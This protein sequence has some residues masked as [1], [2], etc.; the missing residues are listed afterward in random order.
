MNIDILKFKENIK[1]IYDYMVLN[2]KL[3]KCDLIIGCGC[4]DTNIPKKCASLLKEGYAKKILFT[5]GYGTKGEFASPEAL[6][7]KNIAIEEGIKEEDIIVEKEATNTGDN[8]RYSKKII[9]EKNIPSNKILIVHNALSTRR[10]YLTAQN[11]L[12]DKKLIITYPDLTFDEFYK[13]LEQKKMEE[14][15]YTISVILGDIQRIIIYPQLGWMKYEEVPKNIIDAYYILK[16][17]GFD[18]FI[19]SKEKID[20]LIKESGV[21]IEKANY[22]S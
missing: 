8:F 17:M 7:F 19:L 12:E 13:H 16:E 14:L 2:Q 11:I 5:G 4:L 20:A 3:E 21:K 9:E 10:T 15:R 18:K 1:I 22:F 6:V